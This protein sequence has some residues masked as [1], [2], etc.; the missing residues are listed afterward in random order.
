MSGMPIRK[1]Q[2]QI[3]HVSL[4]P[5]DDAVNVLYYDINIPDTVIGTMDDVAAAYNLPVM[6]QRLNGAYAGMTIKAYNLPSGNPP[7]SG[8][9]I[10]VKNYALPPV[11]IDG[12]CELALALSYSA[13]D[14]AA[15]T[16]KRRGRI[17]LPWHSNDVRMRPTGA[18]VATVLDFGEALAQAGNAGNSTWHMFS[19]TDNVTRKIESISCDNE[20]D[21]QRRRGLRAT[22]RTRRDVQ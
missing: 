21:T 3:H 2:V 17:Y 7:T 6:R 5:R 19:P 10:E 14:D 13:D 4:L 1:L 20:W 15:G 11:S 8:P 22:F 16:P 18:M 12:P 9:P